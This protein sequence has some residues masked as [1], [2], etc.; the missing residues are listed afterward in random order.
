MKILLPFIFLLT[1][2]DTLQASPLP[3]TSQPPS[4]PPPPPR[5]WLTWRTWVPLAGATAFLGGLATFV[6]LGTHSEESYKSSQSAAI[7]Q[8]LQTLSPEERHFVQTR[9]IFMGKKAKEL[10][11]QVIQLLNYEAR[12]HDIPGFEM[13]DLKGTDKRTRKEVKAVY[14]KL[15]GLMEEV[16]RTEGEK[17]EMER[18]VEHATNV[19]VNAQREAAVLVAT[20]L[21][22]AWTKAGLT[23]PSPGDTQH[24]DN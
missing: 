6:Y 20:E 15:R 19:R 12:M 4:P 16:K 9:H 11:P 17:R 8:T 7:E 21:K 24:R 3:E 14:G 2:F 1:L 23:N 22:D 18:V 13:P 10:S 5:K